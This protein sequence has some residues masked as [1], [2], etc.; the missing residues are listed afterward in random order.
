VQAA[1][2]LE[3]KP[4]VNKGLREGA[5]YAASAGLA[6]VPSHSSLTRQPQHTRATNS[7]G[8]R[9]KMTGRTT[10]RQSCPHGWTSQAQGQPH[11][12]G[13]EGY[14]QRPTGWPGSAA[15]AGLGAS[16]NA[17][18][19]PLAELVDSAST[20]APTAPATGVQRAGQVEET[21]RPGKRFAA[22]YAASL[23]SL[24]DSLPA[25]LTPTAG[26]SAATAASQPAA[27]EA[28]GQPASG[29]PGSATQATPAL[30]PA[31]GVPTATASGQPTAG[32]PSSAN[33]AASAPQHTLPQ[34][35]SLA[36]DNPPPSAEV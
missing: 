17:A 33:Q 12:H 15:V 20:L 32:A 24:S 5:Y 13:G 29:M 35:C 16:G 25:A 19:A 8:G 11:L 22:D 21:C 28:A 31:A 23:P 10:R 6:T 30:P 27:A 18:H 36:S 3:G 2:A 14:G 7:G 26:I 4:R 9:R 34:S 1:R